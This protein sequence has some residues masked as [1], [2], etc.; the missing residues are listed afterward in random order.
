MSDIETVWASALS[1]S[2]SAQRAQLI[3]LIKALNLGKDEWVTIYTDNRYPFAMAHIH[4][5]I[6]QERGLLK[7][8]GKDR[9]NK[10]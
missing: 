7:A 1:A 2:T 9:K 4:G 8:E 3:A 6:Y 10:Q 5:A